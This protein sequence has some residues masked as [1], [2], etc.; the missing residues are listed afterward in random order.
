M[1]FYSGIDLHSRQSTLCV[2]DDKD[3]IHL[4]TNVSNQIEQTLQ[5][6]Q[7]FTP[8]HKV[9]VEATLNWYWLVDGL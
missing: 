1:N 7:S 5:P 4:R 3:N 9:P 8:F 6:L 2:I